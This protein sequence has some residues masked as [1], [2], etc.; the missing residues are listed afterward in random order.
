M[1][2]SPAATI[3]IA[4]T[5]TSV[6]TARV[7]TNRAGT[8]TFEGELVRPDADIVHVRNREGTTF[9]IP[10]KRLSKADCDYVRGF[11]LWTWTG[12]GEEQ[13]CAKL[14]RAWPNGRVKLHR[15]DG[16]EFDTQ[17][18]KLS[19]GDQQL[20]RRFLAAAHRAD[21]TR[22]IDPN[23]GI[24]I[25][26]VAK[27][28]RPRK[29]FL[30]VGVDDYVNDHVIPDLSYCG[31]DAAKLAEAF[32]NLGYDSVTVLSAAMGNARLRPTQ[33]NVQLQLD[34]LLGVVD[35]DGNVVTPGQVGPGDTVVLAFSGHG[36]YLSDAKGKAEGFLCSADADLKHPDT[37]MLAV[38]RVYE[39]LARSRARLKV[40]LVDACRNE[41]KTREVGQPDAEEQV[42]GL[43]GLFSQT[44]EGIVTF[45]SCALGNR[46]MEADDL[47]QGVFSYFLVKGLL[48]GAADRAS[49]DKD[50]Y[51]VRLLNLFTYAENQVRRYSQQRQQP[52]QKPKLSAAEVGNESLGILV[53]VRNAPPP[54]PGGGQP[55]PTTEI[56]QDFSKVAAGEL[57]KGW[58]GP[59]G[60]FRVERRGP[61]A[62]DHGTRR[63]AESN[64]ATGRRPWRVHLGA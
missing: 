24:R 14:V 25:E 47:K 64:A 18:E 45:S 63:A 58:T 42:K 39:Q 49:G 51:Q 21:Y 11:R 22:A 54:T 17:L 3:I 30:A 37:T 44:R 40:L 13:E 48:G 20:V 23:R 1:K 62:S 59:S 7:W 55:A 10:L 53:K 16:T 29:W 43:S 36:V 8:G 38:S 46:S 2:R 50:A 5:L 9:R 34:A 19:E 33:K 35:A 28:H 57:P 56:D 60:A 12:S 31:N 4:L 41:V 15:T 61:A 27:E 32:K 6:G 26:E 52:L